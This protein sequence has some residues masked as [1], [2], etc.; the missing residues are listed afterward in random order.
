MPD[1]LDNPPP[2]MKANQTVEPE[3]PAAGVEQLVASYR[4]DY[5]AFLATQV[6]RPSPAEATDAKLTQT[7]RAVEYAMLADAA[8]G[9]TAVPDWHRLE[10][11]ELEAAG[12]TPDAFQTT[13]SGF[14]AAL[15]RNEHTG[16]F[17]LAFAGTDDRPDWETNLVQGVGGLAPQYRQAVDLA[18][19]VTDMVGQ[20]TMV[21]HSLG[22]GLA[23]TAAI[24]SR[25]EA[26]T[27]NAAGVHANIIGYARTGEETP[28]PVPLTLGT[29]HG[30]PEY[31][32]YRAAEAQARTETQIHVVN[33]R[34][35]GE[36]LTAIQ[37]LTR[38]L[39]SAQ[40]E[41]VDVPGVSA[42]YSLWNPK[43]R[44]GLHEV[45]HS[46]DGLRGQAFKLGTQ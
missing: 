28:A 42:G 23:A 4:T 10:P 40:G 29:P 13:A 21:G 36:I 14:K 34:T 12:M 35:S 19:A 46:I 30:A 6:D 20:T 37:T 38:M 5:G 32:E 31:M 17:V 25:S 41:Q 15:F 16:E 9:T 1:S 7:Q 33:Y 43:D 39:P 11:A 2:T 3:G 45:T 24:A 8:Y 18:V 44:V 26:V 27:F 22:G